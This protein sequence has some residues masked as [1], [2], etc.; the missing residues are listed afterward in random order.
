MNLESLLQ[1]HGY[2]VLALGCLLEG[3]TVLVLAG[4]AAHRG[5]LDPW[6]VLAIASSAGFTGDQIAFWLGRQHGAWA[7]RRWPRI[8]AQSE[9]VHVLLQRYHALLIIGVRFA[10]GLR[11]AGP[12]LMGASPLSAMRFTAF[13]A[14]GALLWACVIGGI[15]WI[16]GHTAELMLG[17]MRSHEPWILLGLGA[18]GALLWLLRRR[19]QRRRAATRR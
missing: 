11:L 5:Y 12:V 3:E 9:R 16:F 4:F 14:L 13:N 19:R 17:R 18:A 2:W 10:Y 1:T 8:A 15:G 7:F 6:L